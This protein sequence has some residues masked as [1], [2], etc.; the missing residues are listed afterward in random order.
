[1]SWTGTVMAHQ[2]PASRSVFQNVSSLKKRNS[3]LRGPTQRAASGLNRLSLRNA[4]A[5]V[6]PR[7]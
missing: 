6:H 2:M 3:K 5:T 1:M 4:V 7:G